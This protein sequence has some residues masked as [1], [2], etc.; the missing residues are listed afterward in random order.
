LELGPEGRF[1]GVPYSLFVVDLFS[2][3]SRVG[4]LLAIAAFA[5]T[6]TFAQ[7]VT[8][9]QERD[10]QERSHKLFG[11]KGPPPAKE[12]GR[13]IRGRVTDKNG[14]PVNGAMVEARAPGG[15][16]VTAATDEQG[17]YSIAG[18]KLTADYEVRARKDGLTPATRK[19]SQ[20][21]SRKE[22]YLNFL[23]R[24]DRQQSTTA[25]NDPN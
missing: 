25:K 12:T 11:K 10:H 19:L 4:R 14:E 9:S 2:T 6:F 20:Y 17:I 16:P 5:V 22:V 3:L 15:S 23:L 7:A 21:D 18:L 13:V 1:Q 8:E 24:A